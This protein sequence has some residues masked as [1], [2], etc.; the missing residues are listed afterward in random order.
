M[1]DVITVEVVLLTYD[2]EERVMQ[3]GWIGCLFS[4][5]ISGTHANQN[6]LFVRLTRQFKMKDFKHKEMIQTLE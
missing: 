2:I 6:V 5:D 3:E 1:K 4:N